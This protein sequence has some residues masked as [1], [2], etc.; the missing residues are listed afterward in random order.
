MNMDIFTKVGKT[1]VK[2][3]LAVGSMLI[4]TKIDD[5]LSKHGVNVRYSPFGGFDIRT[6]GYH[7]TEE[8]PKIYDTKH[9]RFNASTVSE[10]S[11]A[12]IYRSSTKTY[13]NDVKLKCAKR[14][15][16][17]AVGGDGNTR[18]VAIQAL[19]RIADSTYSNSLKEYINTAIAEL[20]IGCAENN[21]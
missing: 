1:A 7:D 21:D 3:A 14:I 5:E 15:Y 16:D 13:S 10:R 9:V 12:E 19:G 4:L 2:I 20:A 17:I 6:D 18:L 11:I 8:S